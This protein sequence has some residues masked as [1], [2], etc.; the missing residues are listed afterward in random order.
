[1][2]NKS[3]IKAIIFDFDETMYFS[4]NIKE[5][6]V[7]YINRTLHDLTDFSDDEIVSLMKEYHFYD[8]GKSRVSFGKNCHH[9]GVTKEMWNNYRI[10][11]F[12]QID[13]SNAE[14]VDNCVYE[15]LAKTMQL[16]IV[17]NECY[18]NVLYKAKQL[19]IDLSQFKKIYAP[20]Y[21]NVL[22]YSSDKMETYK[23]VLYE[24]NLSIDEVIVIGDRY[25]VDIEPFEK[26]GG[27]GV[28]IENTAQIE[29]FFQCW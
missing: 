18:E 15:D 16:F 9:F 24:N 11:N 28:L 22:S 21:E 8:G 2:I 29:K 6:Y 1:M 4:S 23:K 10:K 5:Y 20:N 27:Q 12:F 17:S 26:L 3:K 19:N 14:I 7:K 13:Y 25:S